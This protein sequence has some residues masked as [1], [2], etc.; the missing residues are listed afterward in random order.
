ML[1]GLMSAGKKISMTKTYIFKKGISSWDI[2]SLEIKKQISSR[3]NE[4]DKEAL[5]FQQNAILFRGKFWYSWGLTTL[6]FIFLNKMRGLLCNTNHSNSS[7]VM[8]FTEN[9]VNIFRAISASRGGWGIWERRTWVSSERRCG[10]LQMHGHQS[11]LRV[12]FHYSSRRF[13]G[14]TSKTQANQWPVG[15]VC[16]KF[17]SRGNGTGLVL[18]RLLLL[19]PLISSLSLSLICG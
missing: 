5:H 11:D 19:V 1:R 18:L 6:D 12:P 10:Y 14:S 8:S 2:Q 7:V 17:W 13:Q 9:K 15:M 4:K 16:S 3:K